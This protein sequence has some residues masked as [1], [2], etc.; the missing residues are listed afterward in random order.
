M[1]DK[2]PEEEHFNCTLKREEYETLV[3]ALAA[4]SPKKEPGPGA[5][6]LLESGQWVNLPPETT[7]TP[8]WTLLC[9][10]NGRKILSFGDSYEAGAS[11]HVLD[12]GDYEIGTWCDTEI[13]DAT[14]LCVGAMIRVAGGCNL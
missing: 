8:H 4:V 10:D 12:V 11:N 2:S 6:R 1:L 3:S 13:A 14:E 7:V 5:P 9:L